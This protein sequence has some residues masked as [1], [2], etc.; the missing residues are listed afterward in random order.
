MYGG[1]VS[2]C[3]GCFGRGRGVFRD[4][5]VV[6]VSLRLSIKIDESLRSRLSHSKNNQI[7]K[8]VFATIPGMHS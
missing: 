3:L 1:M 4:R 6:L 8:D 2:N 5:G 7:D